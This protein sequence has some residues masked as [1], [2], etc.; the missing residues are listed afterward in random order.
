MN[1]EQDSTFGATAT[2]TCETGYQRNKPKISCQANGMWE[3][4]T[5]QPVGKSS[6][7]PFF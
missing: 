5:C 7:E 3:Q 2:V 1:T 4:A 6:I